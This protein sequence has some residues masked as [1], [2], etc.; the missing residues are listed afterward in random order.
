MFSLNSPISKLPKV[1][2]KTAALFKRLGINSVSDLLFHYPFRYE[3][4]TVFKKIEALVT[5]ESGSVKVIWFN[6][7]F[8]IKQIATGDIVFI[9]GKVDRDFLG[10][11]FNS[12]LISAAKSEIKN[13]FGL[14]PIYSVTGTLTQ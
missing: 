1:G 9:A 4:Y 5:D 6:Q 13:P 2:P 7:P 3:D 12:P 11:Y 10:L 14:V 8:I